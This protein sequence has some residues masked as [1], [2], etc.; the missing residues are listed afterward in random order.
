MANH[1]WRPL[2]GGMAVRFDD[3]RLDIGAAD[4]RVAG[5]IGRC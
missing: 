1:D 2:I 5:P 3:G 4:S